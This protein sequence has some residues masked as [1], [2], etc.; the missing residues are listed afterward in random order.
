MV[1]AGN[2]V[3]AHEQGSVSNTVVQYSYISL[4]ENAATIQIGN[5]ASIEIS[6]LYID[7]AAILNI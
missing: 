2:Y 6:I 7:C 1:S 4:L 3:M 5:A